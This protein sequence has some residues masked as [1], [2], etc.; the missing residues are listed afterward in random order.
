MPK[1]RCKA[2]GSPA[3]MGRA[4]RGIGKTEKPA[5]HLYCLSCDWTS[6]EK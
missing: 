1:V 3:R 2:C 4:K 6:K 5:N